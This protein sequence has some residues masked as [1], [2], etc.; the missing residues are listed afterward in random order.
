MRWASSQPWI[1]AWVVAEL[2]SPPACLD[3]CHQGQLQHTVQV[4]LWQALPSAAGDEGLST[5]S[6][7]QATAEPAHP[8]AAGGGVGDGGARSSL[9]P[10]H[11]LLCCPGRDRDS[12]PTH[13]IRPSYPGPMSPKPP[14]P[15]CPGEGLSLQANSTQC[16]DI[17]MDSGCDP[18]L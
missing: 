7:T 9:P 10:G 14:L 4:G 3:S 15:C 11:L 18:D 12:C 5:L 16:S 1:W 6:C 8:P 17:N 13:S 2:V